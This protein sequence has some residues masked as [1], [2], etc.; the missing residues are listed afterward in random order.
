MIRLAFFVIWL[1]AVSMDAISE[2]IHVPG[3]LP[4]IQDG[5]D[6]ALPGDTVLVAP[7]T[8][9][10]NINFKGKGI[11]VISSDG[12]EVTY[13]DGG[14]PSNPDE[15][16]VVTFKQGEG[17]DAVLEGFTLTNGTGSLIIIPVGQEKIAGGGILCINA[18][19]RISN[20][21]IVNNSVLTWGGGICCYDNAA[22]EIVHNKIMEN[23]G[24]S[25]GGGIF[26]YDHA[27]PTISDNL[28]S[29]N[30][31]N[32]ISCRLYA[33]PIVHDNMI[34]KNSGRGIDCYDYASPEIS[35]NIIKE[36]SSSYAG[37]GICCSHHASPVIDGN[38]IKMNSV[39]SEGGGIY[40]F[41]KASPQI[42][43]NSITMNSAGADGG[44]ICCFFSSSPKIIG[45]SITENKAG[46]YGGGI[47]CNSYCNPE[48]SHNTISE[49]TAIYGG[50]IGCIDRSSPS[51]ADNSITQNIA[52]KGGG[53]YCDQGETKIYIN[54]NSIISNEATVGGGIY[55]NEYTPIMINNMINQNSALEIGGAIYAEASSPA[56]INCTLVGNHAG[57]I[58]GG[59]YCLGGDYFHYAMLTLANSIL[60]S[61]HAPA[62]A[63]LFVAESCSYVFKVDVSASDIEGGQNDVYVD[64]DCSL[65]WGSDVI[66]ESPLFMAMYGNYDYH[67]TYD[68]PCR[69]SGIIKVP[70]SLLLPEYD[71]DGNPRQAYGMIDMGAD[72]FYPNFFCTGNFSPGSWVKA[73]IVGLPNT[74]P[75]YLLFSDGALENPYT[76][77]WGEFWLKAPWIFAGPLGS[78]PQNGVLYLTDYLPAVP[79]A[80]YD[81]YI[82]AL[83]GLDT[84]SLTD[85]FVIEV[86]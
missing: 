74:N 34:E 69:D 13:I 10:E 82:Q 20:N 5:I 55:F 23:T 59:I 16:S 46:K 80:P 50:G 47:G 81:I 64:P 52:S 57:I 63:E 58:A 12:P 22:P 42:I 70:W 85:P 83:I 17:S 33:S 71:F 61:N 65:T 78:I 84:D 4:A 77:K 37:G 15:G 41:D 39:I 67:L 45:N 72:E 27:S 18:S 56:I 14:Q 68:S 53:I 49:N 1:F 79:S 73:M 54:N 44:A 48:I 3:D 60:W 36:N 11:M 32:G 7:G 24:E 51:I 25:D 9:M 62:V 21:T 28:I 86:R 19:P 66:N 75:V 26:C 30:T 31:G 76:L 40:C 35:I 38:I 43:N 6:V 2:T 8:Y 29:E